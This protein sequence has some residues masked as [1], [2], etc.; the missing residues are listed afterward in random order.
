MN[1]ETTQNEKK[2]SLKK[3][4]ELVEIYVRLRDYTEIPE[5][6][7]KNINL[8]TQK[9]LYKTQNMNNKNLNNLIISS[10]N[11]TF[12]KTFRSPRQSSSNK[13]NFN[14]N[15][16][17]SSNNNNSN[18]NNDKKKHS[19]KL[20]PSNLYYIFS[21]YPKCNKLIISPES[22]KGQSIMQ[23]L[24]TP[25]SLLTIN[26]T[27]LSNAKLY[28]YD[29]IYFDENLNQIYSD[30]LKSKI[31]NLFNGNNTIFFSFGIKNSGKK[32]SV[33]GNKNNKG[34][35]NYVLNC[36]FSINEKV[37][38]DKKIQYGVSNKFLF[39]ISFVNIYLN[40]IDVMVDNMEIKNIENYYEIIKNFDDFYKHLIINKYHNIFDIK[41][42]S[43]IIVTVSIN[44][45]DKETEN[46]TNINNNESNNN[47]NN[48]MINLS[49]ISFVIMNDSTFAFGPS[50][51]PTNRLFRESANTY[52][53]ILN[54]CVT[55]SEKRNP[56]NYNSTLL[57]YLH[58]ENILN[59]GTNI[60]L[61]VN[62]V[63]I[64]PNVINHSNI[65]IW[66]ASIRNKINKD[67]CYDD[68]C[69]K[70]DFDEEDDNKNH[71]KINKNRNV[72]N[73]K[74]IKYYIEEKSFNKNNNNNNN[75]FVINNNEKILNPEKINFNNNNNIE[76]E[77]EILYKKFLDLQNNLENALIELNELRNNKNNNFNK[78]DNL[79]VLNENKINDVNKNNKLKTK[80]NNNE[81]KNNFNFT[82]KK[83]NKLNFNKKQIN[84]LIK[85]IKN[86]K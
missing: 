21:T 9:N 17:S 11:T 63:P 55:I 20:K 18:N 76:R 64:D 45:I 8:K 31:L 5:K 22:I 1:E 48:N 59:C 26:K 62:A 81:I 70:N 7:K 50:N 35:L 57:K 83:N 2:S 54:T 6:L 44:I 86:K 3:K 84:E 23:N 46:E 36:L 24:K 66:A 52:R 47:E 65:L 25:F 53:D 37:E 33:F 85:E 73:F 51:A 16:T 32:F 4:N 29:N 13:R 61:L 27:L 75:N 28:E 49:N 42:K 77:Y 67:F 72:N 80:N 74:K 34:L 56:N 82:F 30:S 41:H 19:N 68:D 14:N 78:N 69:D 15:A 39:T 38:E 60:V 43:C 12:S 58:E 79:N 10:N 40:K 71:I